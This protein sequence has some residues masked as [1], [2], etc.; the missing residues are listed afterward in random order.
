MKKA[1]FLIIFT[2]FL[3]AGCT[4]KGGDD[5]TSA[6]IEALEIGEISVD[7]IDGV[8]EDESVYIEV[9]LTNKGDNIAENVYPRIVGLPD[10]FI[11]QEQPGMLWQVEPS[12]YSELLTWVYIPS[13][14]QNT[15]KYPFDV[16][17][18]YDYKTHSEAIIRVASRTW[19]RSLPEDQ[20]EIEKNKLGETTETIESGPIQTNFKLSS[21]TPYAENGQV[22]VFLEITNDGPGVPVNDEVFVAV[23]SGD[24]VCDDAG[25]IK[26]IK[27]EKGQLKCVAHIADVEEWKNIQTSLEISYK[28]SIRDTSSVTVYG[29]AEEGF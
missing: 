22:T 27:G 6:S 7:P 26:L 18:D 25:T 1:F 13:A 12:N 11:L 21:R 29:K 23:S 2:I 9:E 15:V 19:I 17:V 14:L 16:I 3:I 24:L 4:K 10:S 28:Y 8:Y 20:Q 5:T